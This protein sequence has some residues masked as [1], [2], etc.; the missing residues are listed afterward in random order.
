MAKDVKL[1]IGGDSRQ[2][3]AALRELQRTGNTVASA[4]DRDFAQLGIKSSISFDNMRKASQSA[5]DRIKTSGMATQVEL[6]RAEKAL[7][8]RLVRIDEEQFGRREGLLQK[9]KANWMAITAGMAAAGAAI[10]KAFDAAELGA[11]AAQQE[12]SFR[13]LANSVGMSSDAII[14]DLRRV[15]SG[16]VSTQQLIEKAGTSMLLGIEAKY[17]PK[18]MEIARASSR[19]TGQTIT[20]AFA[21]LSLASAR[22]SKM[23]LDNLGIMVDVEKANKN[24]AAAMNIVGRE[25]NDVESK[26]AFLNATM[27]AGQEI[28]NRVNLQTETQSEKLGRLKA[29]MEDMRD[30]LYVGVAGALIRVADNLDVVVVGLAAMT[31]AMVLNNAATL[32]TTITNMAAAMKALAASSLIA[33]GGIIAA[34]GAGAYMLA[35]EGV[36][37]LDK[38][39]YANYDFSLTGEAFYTA[40]EARNQEAEKKMQASLAARK[41]TTAAAV[42]LSAEEKKAIESAEKALSSYSKAVNDLGKEQ[43]KLAESGYQRDLQRMEEY[44]KKSGVAATNMEQPLRNYLAIL[45]Q[46]DAQR[47]SGQKDIL[48]TLKN[49]QASQAA[50]LNQQIAIASVEKAG[51]EERLKAWG[52]YYDKLKTLHNQALEEMKKKQQ[53][54]LDARKFITDIDKAL[55]EKFRPA[56]QQSDYLKTLERL[57]TA[58]QKL[59][60][61][62]ELP[63]PERAN[64]LQ[65]L[66][67]SLKD[68]PT[69]VI[70]NGSILISA[71]EIEARVREIADAAKNGYLQVYETAAANATAA[72]AVFA[73][74]LAKAETAMTV[75]Q[76]KIITL[77]GQILALSKAVTLTL[78][79]Q[80]TPAILNIQKALDNLR[81]KTVTVRINEY[82]STVPSGVSSYSGGY[83]TGT[84]YVPA[85]GVYQL[86]RG[87]QV[88]T[89]QESSN[90]GANVTIAPNISIT[91]QGSDKATAEKTARELSRLIVPELRKVS[92]R[93]K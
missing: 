6:A 79:D 89:R 59:G 43:A 21:D 46:I 56:D 28:I 37:A 52:T 74:G 45:D 61:A 16:T 40:M 39:L 2:A 83:A 36:K 5:Y 51:T 90:Q 13:N 14:A 78:N 82:V 19:I 65:E 31:S 1:L 27:A 12:S 11:K 50:I 60:K 20:Q 67:N 73:E 7:A 92:S 64:A 3:E 26:Q 18:M 8:D 72:E 69:E 77:D 44:Y 80:A 49:L 76:D 93:F 48:A 53:D 57:D 29:R 34:V 54:L 55:Q 42:A 10:Y 32:V 58:N 22:Q 9:F 85:T 17:L 68:F 71:Q 84:S 91:M 4:L 30:T 24:Y 23:I 41:V 38:A 87:E 70:E 25:L 33:Q 63:S 15:S 81:D 86:H 62:F 75:L 47:V 88:L 35:R 66:L